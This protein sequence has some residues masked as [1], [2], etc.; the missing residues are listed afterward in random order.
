M[1]GSRTQRFESGAEGLLRILIL[2]QRCSPNV[3]AALKA[4]LER[5]A[6]LARGQETRLPVLR[7]NVPLNARRRMF[8]EGTSRAE[9]AVPNWP[10]GQL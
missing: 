10:R 8:I 1:G 7:I 9:S 3:T 5:R 2:P 6:Q 4:V